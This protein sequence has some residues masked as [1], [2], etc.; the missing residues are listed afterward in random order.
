MHPVLKKYNASGQND[1]ATFENF[2]NGN[3]ILTYMF[4][5]MT[6]Q[7]M[8]EK[9]V[10][11]ELEGN[12]ATESGGVGGGGGG[13]SGGSGGSWGSGGSG[14]SGDGSSGSSVT[15]LSAERR[16][17]ARKRPSEVRLLALE[18]MAKSSER[19]ADES[20]K[21]GL[22]E[23][24]R[25]MTMALQEAKA[26]KAPLVVCEAI[27]EELLVAVKS[28]KEARVGGVAEG[29]GAAAGAPLP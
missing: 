20:G 23:T 27:E 15:L 11:R 12:V 5:M 22:S 19:L 24:V 18:S 28:M 6:T 8:L 10:N 26:A 4:S 29:E 1:P 14:G 21:R 3:S 17:K 16:M 13:G 25:N 2:H 9:V 7:S